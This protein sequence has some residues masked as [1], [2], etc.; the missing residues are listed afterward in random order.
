MKEALIV[1]GIAHALIIVGIVV[2]PRF[3]NWIR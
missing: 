1:F 3:R 2:S